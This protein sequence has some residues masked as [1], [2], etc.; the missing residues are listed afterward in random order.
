MIAMAPEKEI[1]DASKIVVLEGPQGIRKRPAMYIGSTGS[2]G[3][4]HLLFEVIDNAVDEALAGY[5]KNITITLTDDKTGNIAEVSDDGRGIPVDI[6]TKYGKPALE[7]IMTTLHKGAKFTNDTYKVSGGLHGVGLTVVNALSEFTEVTVRRDEKVYKQTFS[8]G[9]PTSDLEVI[10]ETQE[11]GTTIKFKPDKEIFP[12]T[13]F[14]SALL[15]DRLRYTSFLNPKVKLTL[16]DKRFDPIEQETFHS[17]NGITDFIRY[18][19][20]DKTALTSVI[21]ESITEGETEIDF[22]L[23]YNNTYDEKIEAF[24]NN[25]RTTEGGTH[26]VG[27]H[28]GLTRAILNYINRNKAASKSDT[29]ITGEDIREGLTI[30]LSILIQNPE[31]EGQ[32]KEKLGNTAIKNIVETAVYSHVTRYL[33]EH[34]SDARAIVEKASSAAVARESSRKARD[35]ARK[36]SIFD[37]AV[38]PGKLADCIDAD[39]EKTELFIVEGQSAGGSS[40]DGRNKNIQAILPLR[41]KILNVEKAADEKIFDNAEIKAL[42]TAFG[43]GI[44]ETFNAENIRYKKII[45]MTDADVDGSHIR[46]LLLTFFYRY[47]KKI[48]ELGYVFIAMPPLYKVTKDKQIYYCYSD[49]ELNERVKNMGGKYDLQR[50]KGLGEMNPEQLWETTMD[51]A[52]RKMKRVSIADATRTD[53]LF[54]ILMGLDVAQRRKFLHEHAEEVTSLDI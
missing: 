9:F 38:L 5:A 37:G 44:N 48:I 23:Q 3:V 1:Y 20:R 11:T 8:R 28:S 7:I 22:A 10:G 30:V 29:K 53:E 4:L 15:K 33:E 16:T 35:L 32:T 24:V 41:G 40:K 2:G 27:F 51:P 46:T 19:N 21:S 12:S 25:I 18:L 31:F 52:T 50:Y 47:M 42:V 14:D 26:V 34:P 6:I 13:S 36:K 49:A 45:L 17:E 54:T 39:P 43:T